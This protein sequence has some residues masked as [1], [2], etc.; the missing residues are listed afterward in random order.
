MGGDCRRMKS[1]AWGWSEHRWSMNDTG[2]FLVTISTA[3][4]YF[5]V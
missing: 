1:V 3:W 5:P 4:E 2:N